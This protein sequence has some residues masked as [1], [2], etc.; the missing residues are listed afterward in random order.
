MGER[1]RR[2]VREGKTGKG[3]GNLVTTVIYRSRRICLEYQ[4]FMHAVQLQQET[5]LS[6]GSDSTVLPHRRLGSIS[7]CCYSISSL[8]RDIRF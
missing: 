3:M 8:F 1:E 7:D 2:K 6:L 4:N 5:K